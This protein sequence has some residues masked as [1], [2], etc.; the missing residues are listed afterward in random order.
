MSTRTFFP[1][2]VK[3]AALA[4]AAALASVAQAAASV[5][6]ADGMWTLTPDTTSLAVKQEGEVMIDA[7]PVSGMM[8]AACPEITGVTFTMPQHGGHGGSSTPEAM[9]MSSCGYHVSGLTPTMGGDWQLHLDLKQ[10][11]KSTSADIHVTAK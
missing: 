1:A 3:L 2:C 11:G 7:A 9:K 8:P 10:G 5:K 6:T 4:L